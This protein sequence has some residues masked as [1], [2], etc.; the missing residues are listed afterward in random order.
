MTARSTPMHSGGQPLYPLPLK[1]WVPILL[2]AGE[3]QAVLDPA[4]VIAEKMVLLGHPLSAEAGVERRTLEAYFT[5]AVSCIQ[6]SAQR[7]GWTRSSWT[8]QRCCS[9]GSTRRS[10]RSRGPRLGP[11]PQG[12]C[13]FGHQSGFSIA[14]S[15]EA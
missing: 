8:S 13:R 4:L 9:S 10:P 3:L 2:E 11:T 15:S 12:S 6:P 14:G 5:L 7:P 1:E